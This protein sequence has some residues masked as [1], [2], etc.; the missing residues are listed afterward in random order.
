MRR[1]YRSDFLDIIIYKF[2]RRSG[3][4]PPPIDAPSSPDDGSF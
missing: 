2:N 3:A 1:P 4:L